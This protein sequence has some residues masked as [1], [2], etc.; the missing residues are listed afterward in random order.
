MMTL[1][2]VH[3]DHRAVLGRLRTAGLLLRTL[4]AGQPAEHPSC[5]LP[6]SPS[7]R[8]SYVS[9]LMLL[10]CRTSSFI[11]T[12]ECGVIIVSV[13]CVCVCLCVPV[14]A[15]TVE[16]LDLET[17]FLMYRYIFRIPRPSSYVKVMGSRSRSQEQKTGY[18]SVTKYTNSQV[19][20]L[21]LK[22]NL[23]T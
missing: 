4:R 8:C 10:D 22:G 21:R 9:R 5:E 16:N 11:T 15:I 3:D 1:Q 6:P 20:R 13:T 14:C 23:V 19:I 18:M 12:R 2:T 7:C 17:S